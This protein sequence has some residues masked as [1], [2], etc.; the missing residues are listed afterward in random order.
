MSHVN[1]VRKWSRWTALP[2][3]AALLFTLHLSAQPVLVKD[4]NTRTERG[5]SS[6]PSQLCNVNGTLF[7]VSN[8]GVNGPELWKTDGTAAGTVMVKD[9]YPGM[10]GRGPSNLTNVNGTLFFSANDGANG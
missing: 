6:R 4:I 7:F 9:I 8:D 5:G 3:L 1:P 2:L 10:G